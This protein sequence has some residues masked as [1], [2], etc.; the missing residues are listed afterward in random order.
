MISDFKPHIF[1]GSSNESKHIAEQIEEDLS[2]IA[3]CKIW[4]KQFNLGNSAYEDLVSK[5]SLYDYGI[6][7]ASSDDTSTSRGIVKPAPRD[8]IL[9][10]FGLFAGRFGRQRSFLMAESGVRIPSDLNGIT[11]PF[12]KSAKSKKHWFSAPK[13]SPL[14]VEEQKQSI[15]VCCAQI[16]SHIKERDNIFD[17]GFLPSTSLAYGYF[18]NFILKAVSNLLET[19]VLRLGNTCGYPR[20]CQKESSYTPSNEIEDGMKFNDLSLSILIPDN[21][22]SDMFDKIKAHRNSGSWKTIKIDAGSFR[23][24]D[25]FIQAERSKS[26]VLLLSDIPIT[27]NA[28]NDSIKSYIGKSYV[29]YSDA[30]SLMELREIRVFKRV[31]D[32]LISTNPLTKGRVVTEIVDI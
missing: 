12:F 14:L 20:Q 5:L 8:N 27:L 11:L 19:K 15:K 7:V 17:Y 10:E 16:R 25:F 24:F 22:T 6:L 2:D 18:N 29:G 9:F 30:E 28:L 32:Y 3:H 4:Y 13:T 26:G 23:P 31:L 21:L 1:I